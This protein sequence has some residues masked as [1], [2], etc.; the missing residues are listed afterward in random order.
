MPTHLFPAALL[1]I[2][3]VLYAVVAWLFISAPLEW[4]RALEISWRA[5]AGFTEL[6]T[7]YVGL[8]GA[9]ALFF[10][11]CAWLRDWRTPGLAMMA[12]SYVTL[13]LARSWGILVEQ[14][15]NT[16]V[17]QIYVAE[18]LGLV[19]SLLALFVVRRGR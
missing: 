6:R 1:A 10:A 17:L 4:F 16:L 5:S 2:N 13:V 7:A 19:L 8:M 14:A 18:W 3:A 11:L 9:L 12:I 15:Y